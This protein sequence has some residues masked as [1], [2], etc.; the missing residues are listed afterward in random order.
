[1]RWFDDMP[2]RTLVEK[3]AQACDAYAQRWHVRPTLALV[4]VDEPELPTTPIAGLTLRVVST[5]RRNT[6]WV[7]RES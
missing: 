2:K 6:V 4:S 7:G 5:V 1:M 3:I